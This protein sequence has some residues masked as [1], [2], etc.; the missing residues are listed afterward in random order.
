MCCCPKPNVNG[1]PNAYSWDGKSFMTNTPHP[2]E[3]A[4]GD[5][6]MADEPGRCGGIDSHS[7]HIRLVKQQYGGHA[8]LVRHGGG[9]E[10]LPLGHRAE[11][12]TDAA[13]AMDSNAR[14]WFLLKLLSVVRDATDR[15]SEEVT[16]TGARRRLTSAS[17][18]ASN[19]AATPSRSG[20]NRP[21]QS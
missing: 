15:K 12:I 18:R 5:T 20:S 9:T 16:A 1:T 6:L 3:L 11:G 4:E 14:Y 10:R 19:R 13:M 7:H 21:L 17:R 2:P 8:I